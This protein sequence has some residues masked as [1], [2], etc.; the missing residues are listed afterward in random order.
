M[1]MSKVVVLLVHQGLSYLPLLATKADS[2]GL[3]VVAISSQPLPISNITEQQE[4]YA[5]LKIVDQE[6]LSLANVQPVIDELT[7]R[8]EVVGVI[9][10]FE[11]YRLE[12]AQLNQQLGILDCHPDML[13]RALDK[14]TMRQT[15]RQ[16]GLSKIESWLLNEEQ[17][18]ILQQQE[19]SLFVKPRC[20][21][22]SFG[23]FRLTENS[24]WLHLQQLAAEL[25]RDDFLKVAH[26]GR[27]E[28]IA[29]QFI[30]GTEFSYEVVAHDGSYFTLAIHEKTGL[31][32]RDNTVLENVD[33]SPSLTLSQP[34]MLAGADFI[35]QCLR[36][37]ELTEGAF[38]VEVRYEQS[39]DR[40]EIIE[41]NPRIGGGF[42]NSS[43][44]EITQGTS[45]LDAWLSVLVRKTS[46]ETIDIDLAKLHNNFTTP[47][48]ATIGH[49]VFGVPGKTVTRI[50][51]QQKNT[52]P[53]A[54]NKHAKV[55][56]VLPDLSREI[57]VIEG[58]WVTTPADLKEDLDKLNK[59]WV[60]VEYAD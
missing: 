14:L 55:G 8:Y 5:E 50:E 27:F 26:L 39:K 25:A 52:Q 1:E 12:M 45:A 29:E 7:G 33:I 40:W 31:E 32:A 2:L 30:D 16:H 3:K 47:L 24:S 34:Q 18:S 43:V 4:H 37:M 49:Y 54:L 36:C 53:K 9:S 57:P 22:G 20:G 58:M 6:N 44:A 51:M 41:I 21:V 17:F 28:F 42:I 48:Q 56:D 46:K 23:C 15:L 60:D 13:D 59:G 38:H 10:T 19:L 11:G 35:E